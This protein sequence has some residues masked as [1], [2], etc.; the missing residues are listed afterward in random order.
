MCESLIDALTFWCAGFRHVTA[1]FGAA[2]FTA[3]HQRAFAEHRVR[4]VL[5]GYDRDDAGD[6]APQ[7]SPRT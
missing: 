3:D 7:N 5:I 6:R 4:R 2:G 1:S